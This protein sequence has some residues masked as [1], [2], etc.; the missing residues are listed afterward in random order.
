M[1]RLQIFCG[2][3]GIHTNYFIEMNEWVSIA[4]FVCAHIDLGTSNEGVWVTINPRDLVQVLIVSFGTDLSLSFFFLPPPPCYY[5]YYYCDW[6]VFFSWF[7]IQHQVHMLWV[8]PLFAKTADHNVAWWWSEDRLIGMLQKLKMQ[9][10]IL[11]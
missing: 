9:I 4:I 2:Y 6:Y 8:I 1:T 10:G 5:Y 11:V 3:V 7:S